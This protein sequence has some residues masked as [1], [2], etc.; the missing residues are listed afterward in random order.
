LDGPFYVIGYRPT[1]ADAPSNPDHVDLDWVATTHL[2]VTER[3]AT[4]DPGSPEVLVPLA[5][6]VWGYRRAT[7][8]RTELL[9]PIAAGHRSWAELGPLLAD[10]PRWTI[11]RGRDRPARS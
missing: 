7:G 3:P 10:D 11:D 5:G 2:T 6:F 1:F 9:R 8:P 4:A